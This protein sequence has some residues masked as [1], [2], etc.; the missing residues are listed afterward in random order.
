MG[1]HLSNY[2]YMNIGNFHRLI[3]KNLWES[4]VNRNSGDVNLQF[5]W[6]IALLQQ[7]IFLLF[8]LA[9]GFL[10]LMWTFSIIFFFLFSTIYI[11]L[12]SSCLSV[13]LSISDCLVGLKLSLFKFYIWSAILVC[14]NLGVLVEYLSFMDIEWIW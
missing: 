5:K 12:P 2:K 14:H 7:L 4:C 6:K 8:D 10:K 1:G 9:S 11:S 13:S 3:S